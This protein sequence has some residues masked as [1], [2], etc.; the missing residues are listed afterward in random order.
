MR[1]QQAK[2]IGKKKHSKR[3][4]KKTTANANG[5]ACSADGI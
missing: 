4:K 2:H 5:K 1:T 3:E